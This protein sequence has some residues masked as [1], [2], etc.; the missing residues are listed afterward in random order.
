MRVTEIV[1]N[2]N[3]YFSDQKLKELM[4]IKENEALNINNLE[5]DISSIVTAYR[6]E[7]FIDMN[8]TDQDNIIHYNESQSIARLHFNIHEHDKFIVSNIVIRG[9]E[10]TKSYVILNAIALKE[11]DIITPDKIDQ[12]IQRLRRRGHFSSINI[13]TQE[14][15][16]DKG[17]RRLVIQVGERKPRTFRAALGLNTERTL[18]ARGLVELSHKNI[19]GRGR[20]FFSHLRLQSNIAGYL[21][22]D[23]KVPEHLERQTSIMYMEP[24][25]L[26]SRFS[27]QINLSESSQVFSHSYKDN[28]SLTDIVDTVQLDLLVQ[29]EIN[30]FIRLNWV[31]LNWES[32][33]E[34]KKGDYCRLNI[35][36]EPLLCGDERLNIA[37]TGLSINIDRR[38]NIL[39]T[40]DGFLSSA[41][42]EYSGPLYLLQSSD[43]IQFIKMEV[44]HFD[45]RPLINEWVL[46]NN[47]QGGVITSISDM[48]T[49]GIPVSRAFILGGMNSLR[50]FDGLI[51]GERVPDK[52]E[53]PIAGANE[54]IKTRSWLYFLLR[55]ELRFPVWEN[56]MG[57]LFYNGGYVSV[58]GK[59]FEMPYRQAAGFGLR[60]QT[61]VG[62]ISLYMAFK[63]PPKNDEELFIFH[64]SLGAF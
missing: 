29:R 14:H 32:R 62:P 64:L 43:D 51:Q 40:S 56:W 33:K 1:F 6:N 36:A 61:L 26:N 19:M 34:F 59:N 52:Y 30:D 13:S 8:L 54:L 38:N 20:Q 42:V 50:G 55:S 23:S 24:F 45:F 9:N 47:V 53:L 57:T 49:G 10:L 18:T 37:T 27:G 16:T 63:I 4:L 12:S 46:V 17:N 25:L 39:F 44:K 22:I 48:Q 21:N 5:T 41:L 3:K 11:G 2:G 35:P 31:I 60:Y 28:Y 58:S 7:G 15:K